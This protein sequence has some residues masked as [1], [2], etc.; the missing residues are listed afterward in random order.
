MFRDYP[1]RIYFDGQ[2][3]VEA[4]RVVDPYK[5]HFEHKLWKEQAKAR[6]PWP[7]RHG[8]LDVVPPGAVHA[9]RPGAR[10]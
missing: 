6:R 7:W 9:R 2:E 8:L 10:H 5:D 1:Q 4:S 3:G